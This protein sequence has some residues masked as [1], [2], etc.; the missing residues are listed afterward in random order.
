M[1]IR[2]DISFEPLP[3]QMEKIRGWFLAAYVPALERQPGFEDA[4]LLETYSDSAREEIGAAAAETHLEIV[5]QFADENL[6][7]RW[8]VSEDH[9]RVWADLEVLVDYKFHRGWNVLAS[10]SSVP[11]NGS[12]PSTDSIPSS[13]SRG[14]P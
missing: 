12:S 4:V 8:E 5:I 3:G 13:G 11:S 7:S 9:K 14:A 6:R 10:S 1:S 2:L